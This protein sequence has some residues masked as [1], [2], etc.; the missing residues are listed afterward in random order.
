MVVW[1]TR[2]ADLPIRNSGW[3]STHCDSWCKAPWFSLR[4]SPSRTSTSARSSHHRSW[5]EIVL[6]NTKPELFRTIMKVWVLY[7]ATKDGF[8]YVSFKMTFAQAS[9]LICQHD[10]YVKGGFGFTFLDPV[11]Y[12]AFG[13]HTFS[14][15]G[16]Q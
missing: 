11:P 9:G 15:L 4:T 7:R 13:I 6:P 2:H 3:K 8:S 1:W 10:T 12:A 14:D 5:S 16:I